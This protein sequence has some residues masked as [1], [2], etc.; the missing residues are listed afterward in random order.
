VTGDALYRTITLSQPCIDQWIARYHLG[1]GT[2][3][4]ARQGLDTTTLAIGRGQAIG[5]DIGC[6]R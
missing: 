5:T 4:S 1:V 3:Q 2:S 6:A